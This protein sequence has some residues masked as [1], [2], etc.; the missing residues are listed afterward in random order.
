MY[1]FILSDFAHHVHKIAVQLL[2]MGYVPHSPADLAPNQV[3]VCN[4]LKVEQPPATGGISGGCAQLMQ[5]SVETQTDSPVTRNTTGTSD[6]LRH[7]VHECA[8]D[9]VGR[10]L[11]GERDRWS[12]ASNGGLTH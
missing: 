5:T 9:G 10:D 2:G 7:C 11:H 3:G 6:L 4:Q 12:V 8:P 1:P